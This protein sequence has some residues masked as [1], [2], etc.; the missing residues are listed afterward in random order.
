MSD[1][2]KEDILEDETESDRFVLVDPEN[3]AE[4]QKIR[5]IFRAE[6]DVKKFIG[7]RG[8]YSI[9]EQLQLSELVR[10]FCVE[11]WPVICDSIEADII[12]KDDVCIPSKNLN[13][14]DMQHFVQNDRA[15]LPDALF[16]K[17]RTQRTTSKIVTLH[18]KWSK[19]IFYHFVMLKQ[20]LGLGI[21]IDVDKAP[22]E[23]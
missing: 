15:S 10:M 13:Y 19:I 21:S 16:H 14:L 22:A 3:Y 12:S 7:K 4:S 1:E 11:M 20:K 5:S 6:Q 9:D 23:V 17:G 18:S 2:T 8:L